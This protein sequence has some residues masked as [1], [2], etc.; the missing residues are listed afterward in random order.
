VLARRLLYSLD[1]QHTLEGRHGKRNPGRRAARSFFLIAT[2]A[3][4]LALPGLARAQAPG[5][6]A[7]PQAAPDT[8]A[9]PDAAAPQ[10]PAASPATQ[11][12][13]QMQALVVETPAQ[14]GVTMTG[15]LDE[16]HAGFALGGALV[17][18]GLGLGVMVAGIGGDNGALGL[19]GFTTA[20]VGPSFGHFYAGEYGRGLVHTGVRLGAAAMTAGGAAWTVF[21]L[22]DCVDWGGEE[23]DCSPLHAAAPLVLAAG[24][25]L[26]A[27]SII[28]SIRDAPRAVHR[29]NART[30]QLLITPAPIVGPDHSAGVGLQLGA[31]F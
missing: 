18:T 4:S 25:G 7:A 5:Q 12:P 2:V 26:G 15:R 17:T 6:T 20:L 9:M 31:R 21:A 23:D 10:A 13:A 29:H 24:L 27:G 22:F 28:S 3:I 16:K 30:R 14:A 1:M 8:Q 19:I 11:A